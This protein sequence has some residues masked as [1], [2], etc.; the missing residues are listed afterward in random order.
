MQTPPQ[1]ALESADISAGNRVRYIG[2]SNQ[3]STATG[4]IHQI[5]RDGRC[6][7]LV[8]EEKCRPEDWALL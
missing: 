8:Y 2:L 7:R 4:T 1:R 6:L 5:S 3:F